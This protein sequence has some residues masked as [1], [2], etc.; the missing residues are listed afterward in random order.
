[1]K[2]FAIYGKGGSGKSMVA[3]NLSI[4]FARKQLKTLQIGCDPKHDSTR[5]LTGGRKITTVVDILKEGLDKKEAQLT[6]E[7]YL[8]EGTE[9]VG[10]IETGGPESGAGCAGLGIVAAFRL[11]TRHEV[12]RDYDVVIMD[13]LG[14]VVCGGFAMPLTKGL[15]GGVVIVVSDTPM[16]MYAANNIAKAV[17]RYHRNGI[18]LAGLI[19]NSL[20]DPGRITDIEGFAG[21]LD[22][23][24]L[25]TIP[26]DRRIVEAERRAVP[27]SVHD[28]GGEI[29]GLFSSLAD[30]LLEL[31]PSSFP[32]P[33]PMSDDRWDKFMRDLPQ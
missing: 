12:L 28:A 1:M 15:A 4:Q 32:V 9:G 10:C 16:S 5:S 33:T 29:D 30:Q 20:R 17:A 25:A 18:S 31:D 6:K 22:T 19:A 3:S 8:A 21:E 11:L 13:V 14:D 2:R 26:Q 27:V 23:R 24:I 7:A